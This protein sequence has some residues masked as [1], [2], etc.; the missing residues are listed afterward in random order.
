MAN[1]SSSSNAFWDRSKNGDDIVLQ[2][3]PDHRVNIGEEVTISYGG[4]K[5]AAEMLF[6]YGFIDAQS[7]STSEL[8]LNLRPLA[9]D[10]LGEAKLK[11]FSGV[12]SVRIFD[13]AETG[14]GWEAPFL[15]FMILNEE[16]GLKFMLTQQIDGTIGDLQTFYNG[17]DVSGKTASF[18]DIISS[19]PMVE[20]FNLRCVAIL[21]DILQTQADRLYDS[22]D[23]ARQLSKLPENDSIAEVAMR[24][25]ALETSLMGR[26]YQMLDGQVRYPHGH[27]SFT[28]M[29][30]AVG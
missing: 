18:K 3:R 19:H 29:L 13:D 16:D 8:L 17:E 28:W 7:S 5:S 14:L 11:A 15:Y 4:V 22:E 25:R 30:R 2:L 9:D 23:M 26:I 10:P 24:L 21:Q 12:P 6:S 1:H 20:I 27:Y